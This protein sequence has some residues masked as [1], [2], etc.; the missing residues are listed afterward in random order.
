MPLVDT[1]V[2]PLDKECPSVPQWPSGIPSLPVDILCV[3]KLREGHN[4]V[5]LLILLGFLLQDAGIIV[6]L[7]LCQF[8]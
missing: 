8:T 3:P 1:R 2:I 4:V 6:C 7:L 5:H